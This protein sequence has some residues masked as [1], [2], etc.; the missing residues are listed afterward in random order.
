MRPICVRFQ[1][2]GPYMDLQTID[3][4][5][6]QKNGLF[7]ISGETGSGKT[8]I[9][10]AMCYALYGRSSGGLRGD[11]SV[12]RCKQAAPQQ[13]TFVEYIFESGENRYRFYRAIKPKK[14]RK[15]AEEGEKKQ[16]ADYNVTCE[17]QIWQDGAFVPM[18]DS[19]DK[20]TF[21]N[22]KAKQLIGL[23]YDQFRQVIILPQGQFEKLLVSDSEEKEK[24]LVTLF[25]AERW[26][27]MAV[28]LYEQAD[29]RSKALD[30]EK[31]LIQEKLK[32][33]GC[34][35]PEQLQEKTEEAA[36]QVAQLQ[37]QLK[38]LEAETADRRAK[39]EA[40]L[41]EN[42]D[43][44]QRDLLR[45]RL[46]GLAAKAHL[47]SREEAVL[48]LAQRAE[49]I[50]PLF[51]RYQLALERKTKAE[52][53]MQQ[54]AAALTSAE[55]GLTEA[56][57]RQMLHENRRPG[58]EA[59]TQR[60][61]VLENAQG[62]YGSLGEKEHQ[63]AQA[64][65]AMEM[66]QRELAKAQRELSD[67]QCRWE[68]TIGQQKQSTEAFYH[69][70]QLYLAGIGSTLAQKLHENEP[71]PVCGSLSHP[72]PAKPAEGHV[73]E[74]QLDELSEAMGQANR[75]EELAR[76]CRMD[77]EQKRNEAQGQYA[78]QQQRCA[79]AEAEYQQA[80][81]QRIEGIETQQQLT[82]T[83]RQL[84]RAIADFEQEEELVRQT[85]NEAQSN[86]QAA[87]IRQERAEKDGQDALQDFT[88]E[89]TQWETARQDAGFDSNEQYHGACMDAAQMHA[90]TKAVMEYQAS[91]KHA[92][93]ELSALEAQLQGRSQPDVAAVKAQL[94]Q[95]QQQADAVK[96]QYLLKENAQKTMAQDAQTL[97]LRWEDYTHQR[98]R[99]DESVVFAKRL[100]GDYG[101]SLQRY[102]LGVM[103]TS[104]TAAANRLLKTVYGGRYQLYRTNEASGSVRKRGLELEVADRDGRRS[105]TTLSGGEKFLLALSL[106]IGLSTVVQ[107]QG[108][109]VRLEAMFIDE[110]FGSLDR[111]SI[112]DALEILQGIR[113]S[114]GLVG[115]ISHVERLAETIPA[116]I[117]ITKTADGSRCRIS[118]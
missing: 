74:A 20:V 76:K 79:V 1:C 87:Q 32:G 70:Q 41:L 43:F 72:C 27:K 84:K 18:P 13:E 17:C 100:R 78:V 99:C 60:V 3:F 22:E 91:L 114:S 10:D 34:Q 62:V 7:L 30:R 73:T 59:G 2:F 11:L 110:G 94:E 16:I 97:A 44:E 80:L 68:Q 75:R 58:Y 98:L 67:A 42:R 25:H 90:R 113:R 4:T 95:A 88:Q 115:I 6:L 31:L 103:L 69:A 29:R 14:K 33:Y 48:R 37:Q 38:A 55:A 117:E 24:I 106:A 102:V 86:L 50:G 77:A 40:A 36:L 82:G 83:I 111:K 112:D 118:C 104:I 64:K 45:A 49:T 92:Q 57:R 61:I 9:L 56:A 21:L 66:G 53:D 108:G 101:V 52:R 47:V 26:Q 51:A 39:Q 81:A 116:K 63:A 23:T 89:Q 46:E 107:A 28:K 5:Q 96:G 15:P 109:G 105:V 19:K 93:E 12:M 54:A 8:T 35:S 71:C 85:L 65:N